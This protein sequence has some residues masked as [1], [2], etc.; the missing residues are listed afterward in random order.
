MKYRF[1]I[2]LSILCLK[3]FSQEDSLLI[4]PGDSAPSFILNLKENSIQSFT[5]PY[6]RRILLLHFWSSNVKKSRADNIYL[7]R[8]VQ[9]YRN[10]Q[11]RSAEGFQIISIAVQTDK[12]AWANAIALDTLDNF[13]HGIALRGY[14][15]EACLKYGVRRIPTD[16]LI[17]EKGVVLAVNPSMT[18]IENLLD[19]RKNIQPVLKDVVGKLA[20]SSDKTEVAKFIK[21]YLFNYYG[22]SIAKTITNLKGEFTFSD[23]KLNQDFILKIDN[24]ID[25]T[26]SDPIALYSSK[27]DFLMDGRT[28]DNGFTFYISARY[29]NRL[30]ADTASSIINSLG[31]I[32]VTKHLAF[33]TNGDG[34]TP[35]D[36]QQLNSIIAMLQK[37]KDTQIEITTHTDARMDADYAMQL[38]TN[39]ATAVK[40]YLQK[41]GIQP[42]RIKAIAKGNTELRKICEGTIDCREEDHRINR[43]VEFLIYKN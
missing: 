20:Q 32:D 40:N 3:S 4:K 8:I 5:M 15:D 25:I 41:K 29:S 42:A 31:Q 38:T 33:Y 27:D 23:M 35:K 36:E 6:M 21:L 1:L 18:E 12:H 30:T 43:R 7:N 14:N 28:K 13:T 22:D 17:D 16:I 24:K 19:E 34:L 11:Y 2:I 26:T 10:S 9:R 37:D 39:Q